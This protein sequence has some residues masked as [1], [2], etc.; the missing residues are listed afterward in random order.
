MQGCTKKS[1]KHVLFLVR[2]RCLRLHIGHSMLFRATHDTYYRCPSDTIRYGRHSSLACFTTTLSSVRKGPSLR[3]LPATP[4]ERP[5][6]AAGEGGSS[7]LAGS[8]VSFAARIWSSVPAMKS[9]ARDLEPSICRSL[10]KESRSSKMVGAEALIFSWPHEIS[11]SVK[12]SSLRARG[13]SERASRR[14][15][16][17]SVSWQSTSGLLVRSKTLRDRCERS[18]VPKLL[19]PPRRIF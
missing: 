17:V 8:R 1:T 3:L 11:A 5:S 18:S 12:A 10:R 13:Q 6:H 14:D 16:V 4:E 15:A 7:P 9:S 19:R 2:G